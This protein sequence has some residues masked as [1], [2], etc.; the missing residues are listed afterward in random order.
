MRCRHESWEE[1]P[2]GP[3][4]SSRRCADCREWLD[5]IAKPADFQVGD[6]V[7]MDGVVT[8]VREGGMIE[9]HPD[10][11]DPG[12]YFPSEIFTLIERPRRKLRVGSVWEVI[13]DMDERYVVAGY[14][15]GVEN[16]LSLWS[17]DEYGRNEL[18]FDTEPHRWREVPVEQLEREAG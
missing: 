3:G 6:R 17:G 10:G 1:S 9:V 5:P 7:R 16:F 12:W 14:V 11:C 13:G 18:T 8:T 4:I 15:N 2:N